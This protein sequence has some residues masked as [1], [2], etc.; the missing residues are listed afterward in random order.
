MWLVF[1]FDLS[2]AEMSPTGVSSAD[3]RSRLG[4]F[5]CAQMLLRNAH[6]LETCGVEHPRENLEALKAEVQ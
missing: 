3:Y 4:D 5:G 6:Y 1:I 2:K